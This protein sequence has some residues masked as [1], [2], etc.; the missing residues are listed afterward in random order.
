MKPPFEVSK[1][2]FSTAVF[3]DRLPP[4][5]RGQTSQR[6]ALSEAVP[7]LDS[8]GSG[9][10]L[11]SWDEMLSHHEGRFPQMGEASNHPIN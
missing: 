7:N 4:F 2:H 6:T 10:I 3:A 1:R 5:G 8:A 9:S 11:S